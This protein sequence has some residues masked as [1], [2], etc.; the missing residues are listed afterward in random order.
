MQSLRNAQTRREGG[1]V[2]E[3]IEPIIQDVETMVIV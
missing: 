1:S 3:I 2:Q